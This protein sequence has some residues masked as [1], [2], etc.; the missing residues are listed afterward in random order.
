MPKTFLVKIF[1]LI[2]INGGNLRKQ[3]IEK[4]ACE[5]NVLN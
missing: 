1:N 2:K 3:K 5:K 4:K